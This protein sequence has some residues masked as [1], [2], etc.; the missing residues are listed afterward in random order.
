MRFTLSNVALSQTFAL[1]AIFLPLTVL[2]H[3]LGSLPLQTRATCADGNPSPCICG[4]AFGIREGS[5]NC[6]QIG[7]HFKDQK[8][9]TD[10]TIIKVTGVNY[11]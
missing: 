3:P 7:F 1:I 6:P 5:L 10:G 8:S 9:Q 11:Y 2:A 4:N